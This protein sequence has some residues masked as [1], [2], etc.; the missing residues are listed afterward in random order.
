MRNETLPSLLVWLPPAAL[1][2][3]STAPGDHLSASPALLD[4]ATGTT[5]PIR[6]QPRWALVE[7]V[8]RSGL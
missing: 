7:L 6:L 2:T 5:G 1:H 8:S 4:Q 3:S